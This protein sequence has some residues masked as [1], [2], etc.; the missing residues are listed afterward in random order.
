MIKFSRLFIVFALIFA[1]CSSEDDGTETGGETGGTD[2]F[3]RGAMLVNWADNIIV[4]A[5]NNILN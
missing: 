1:A 4:P 2:S 3:D 5:Y